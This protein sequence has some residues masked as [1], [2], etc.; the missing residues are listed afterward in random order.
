[1]LK[2]IRY[3][4]PVILEVIISVILIV[5][6]VMLQ[7]RIPNEMADVSQYIAA[8]DTQSIW[9]MGGRMLL[10]C[11]GTLLIS[12]IISFTTSRIGSYFGRELRTEIFKKVTSFSV[13]EYDKFGVSSMITRTTNDVQ[14]VQQIFMMGLRILVQA[15]AMIVISVIY[16]SRLNMKLMTVLLV[17]IPIIL[18]FIVII[19]VIVFPLMRTW[20]SK[21]DRS[22]LVLRENLTGVRVIRAFVREEEESKRYDAANRDLTRVTIKA[23][24]VMSLLFPGISLIMQFTYLAIFFTGFMDFD[25]KSAVVVFSSISSIMSVAQ[26]TLQIMMAILMVSMIFVFVARSK[27]SA[28]RINEILNSKSNLI[29]PESPI[30]LDK[31][32]LNGQVEF[33]H[34]SFAFPGAQ[35]KSLYDI[36]FTAKKGETTAIIGSTGSGKSTIINLIPRF[37][38]ATEGEVLVD[39][40]N[41]K[42]LDEIQLRQHIGFVPQKALLFSGTI[43]DNLRFGNNATDEE[44]EKAA[45]IAQA[46]HFISKKENGF[47]SQVTQGGK[48]FSGGQRQRLCI[49]RALAKNAEIYVFD[50]SFSALDFK[51][52]VKVRHAL[53]KYTKDSTVIIVGQRVSSIMDADNIIVL[54]EGKIVDQGSHEDLLMRCSVYQEIVKSQLDQDEVENT[55]RMNKK[56]KEEKEE[57]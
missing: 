21:I 7:L 14:Q 41:V 22:T 30:D 18:I 57:N 24:R 10:L 9:E 34:V 37:Y 47:D 39:G 17:S 40:I 27:V 26:Y 28:D 36:S 54:D 33:K 55:I 19:A 15:P 53:K 29:N 49:A 2:L 31:T 52:D 11:L 44:I 16:A 4:K 12:I 42:D 45:E 8:K 25:N 48:N 38:D 50:D 32:E 46:K 3:L 23:N 6:Q 51:T 35:E 1:M 5:A 56:I 13:A 20:Q 43:K